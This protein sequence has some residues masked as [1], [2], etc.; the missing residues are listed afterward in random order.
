M[1]RI[2]CSCLIAL[3][4]HALA[5][6]LPTELA[7][8]WVITPVS[9]RALGLPIQCEAIRLRFLEGGLAEFT[10]GELDYKSRVSVTARGKGYEI[11]QVPYHS[12]GRPNCEGRSTTHLFS[13]FSGDAYVE[14]ADWVMRIYLIGKE[15]SVVLVYAR[16]WQ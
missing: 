13:R 9:V 10:S 5:E 7:G 16:K 8:T 6:P 11:V 2:C 1:K 12:N 4:G 15:N 14:I 3:L